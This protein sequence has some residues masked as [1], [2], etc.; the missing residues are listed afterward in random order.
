MIFMQKTETMEGVKIK[1]AEPS[2]QRDNYK[3]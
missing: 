3:K 2:C 1:Y